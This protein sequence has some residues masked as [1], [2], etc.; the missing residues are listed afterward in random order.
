[1]HIAERIK[2]AEKII[3][4]LERSIEKSTALGDPLLQKFHGEHRLL[5]QNSG[6]IQKI[7]AGS[8]DV[9]AAPPAVLEQYEK[10]RAS[11]THLEAVRKLDEFAA[12]AA[13]NWLHQIAQEPAAMLEKTLAVA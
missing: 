2:R 7:L 10:A 11:M 3:A 1:V 13:A 6:G 8:G 4:K 12:E 5:I 9:A